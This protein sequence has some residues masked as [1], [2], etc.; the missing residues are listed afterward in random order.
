MK[1]F[2][3]ETRSD[4]LAMQLDEARTALKLLQA[5]ND[6]LNRAVGEAYNI[7]T[8]YLEDT[9]TRTLDSGIA[10]LRCAWD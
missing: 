3:P 2:T 1:P 10:T 8:W 4:R 9:H 6:R 7:F 5:E